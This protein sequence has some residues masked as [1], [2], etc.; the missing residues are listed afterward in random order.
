MIR[1]LNDGFA[2]RRVAEEHT[3]S[4]ALLIS[5]CSSGL[6][7]CGPT[8][9]LVPETTT[10]P[11]IDDVK[12][13]TAKRRHARQNGS[14]QISTPAS[15]VVDDRDAVLYVDNQIRL[16]SLPKAIVCTVCT[17]VDSILTDAAGYFCSL[18]PRYCAYS[19]SFKRTRFF[20]K[21]S[22]FAS[23][24]C[25]RCA[26]AWSAVSERQR[27]VM[28]EAPTKQKQQRGRNGRDKS[29]PNSREKGKY[30]T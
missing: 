27:T 7:D 24:G 16:P 5:V 6:A 28:W 29:R 25:N 20:S 14:L 30:S 22:R 26:P 23:I 15:V 13:G 8:A 21:H 9:R 1:F 17:F 12:E 2:K 4:T 10:A 3:V 18:G 19:P 11:S